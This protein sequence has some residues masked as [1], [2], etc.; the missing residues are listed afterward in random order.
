MIRCFVLGAIV[1]A[2]AGIGGP[3]FA[4][5]PCEKTVADGAEADKCECRSYSGTALLQVEA[6]PRTI[7]RIA[8][9]SKCTCPCR[10]FSTTNRSSQRDRYFT[11]RGIKPG[12]AMT[13]DVLAQ[14]PPPTPATGNE[15][16]K[17]LVSDDYQTPV[18]IYRVQLRDGDVEQV[19]IQ[20]PPAKK[21]DLTR[22]DLL[23]TVAVEKADLGKTRQQSEQVTTVETERELRISL[24]TRTTTTSSNQP[25]KRSGRVTK[26]SAD[27][28]H[29]SKPT[30]AV[31]DS[32]AESRAGENTES[33]I[34]LLKDKPESTE[35]PPTRKP[36]S[37]NVPVRP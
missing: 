9:H 33:P 17:T 24:K 28:S 35:A 10:E 18:S 5:P 21:S 7:I 14:C 22:E 34:P 29:D 2:V 19:V 8:V 13:V 25:R 16:A 30:P 6:P 31:N 37:S 20:A 15:T 12:V 26:P 23:R 32:P 1:G 3:L 11:I 4:L 36:T 27:D